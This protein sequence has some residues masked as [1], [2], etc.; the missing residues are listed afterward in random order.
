MFNFFIKGTQTR[1]PVMPAPFATISSNET[2]LLGIKPCAYSMAQLY[3]KTANALTKRTL[4]DF[5]EKSKVSINIKYPNICTS[6]SFTN[7]G[8]KLA[9]GVNE[10]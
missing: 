5:N 3:K 6:L 10:K 7:I 9:D 4:P 1:N 2:S 8:A